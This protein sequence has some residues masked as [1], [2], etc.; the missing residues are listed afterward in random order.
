MMSSTTHPLQARVMPLRGETLAR[1]LGTILAPWFIGGGATM[2][3]PCAV[4]LSHKEAFVIDLHE[5][6]PTVRHVES[7]AE[8]KHKSTGG[9]RSAKAYA[10]RSAISSA[11]DEENR[12][13]AWKRHYQDIFASLPSEASVL[14][15][16]PGPAK[17]QFASY[18]RDHYKSQVEIVRVEPAGKMSE[19][20]MV[21][22]AKNEFGQPTRVM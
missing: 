15:M 17:A 22:Y 1:Q 5:G 7:N 3:N 4:W 13:N 8:R 10:H 18:L 21:A 12:R 6:S 11:R 14:I 20:Q 9:V 2:R 19:A 16:G